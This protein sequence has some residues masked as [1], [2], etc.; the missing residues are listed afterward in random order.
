MAGFVAAV[1]V[2][3]FQHNRFLALRRSASKAVAS[4]VWEV[5]SGRVELGEAPYEAARREAYEE[6]GMLITLDERPITAYQA[7]YGIRPMI[8]LVYRGQRLGGEVLLS[9]E[10]DANSWVTGEEFSQ[11]CP[12]GKLADAARQAEELSW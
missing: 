2:L 11:L 10:H 8:V 3:I 12:F 4:G 7:A 9:S 6:T 1:A 5:V